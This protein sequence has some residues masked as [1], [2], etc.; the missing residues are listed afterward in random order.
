M[1]RFT[2][3]A[4]A[5]RLTRCINP[6]CTSAAGRI[7]HRENRPE[8]IRRQQT[9]HAVGNLST[10]QGLKHK[11]GLSPVNSLRKPVENLP[12]ER[13]FDST[14]GWQSTGTVRTL[15]KGYLKAIQFDA[16]IPNSLVSRHGQRAASGRNGLHWERDNTRQAYSENRLL[17]LRKLALSVPESIDRSGGIE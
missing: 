5:R 2:G 8:T 1:G 17:G 4:E 6:A 14:L 16:A 15:I 11:V 3:T 13:G 10:E 12:S 7:R 9:G